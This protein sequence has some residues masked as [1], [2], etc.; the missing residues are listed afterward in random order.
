MAELLLHA[1]IRDRLGKEAA[2]KLRRDGYIPAVMY[3]PK[4]NKPVH[5]QLIPS[6]LIKVFH[7]PKGFVTPF[8]VKVGEETIRVLVKEFQLDPV[9]RKI[10]HC[11]LIQLY[12]DIEVSVTVPVETTGKSKGEQVGGKLFLASKNIKV[13]CVPDNLPSKIVVDVTSLGPGQVLY[14]D[15]VSYPRG[16]RPIYRTR[17]PIVVIEPPRG[18][19]SAGAAE[20]ESGSGS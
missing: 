7:G 10:I 15:E 11:D 19:G 13:R 20:E 12:D 9:T 3:G 1:K 5:L 4:M 2:K 18:T 8:S 17:H 14:V 6:E 16:V